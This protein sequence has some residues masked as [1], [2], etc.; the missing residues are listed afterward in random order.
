MGRHRREQAQLG[1]QHRRRVGDEQ[2]GV[3]A[4]GGGRREARQQPVTL[5]ADDR[6]GQGWNPGIG[7]AGRVEAGL[8]GDRG[9]S[10]ADRH[11]LAARR[12]QHMGLGIGSDELD[13]AQLDQEL[14]LVRQRESRLEDRVGPSQH[15]VE[16]NAQGPRV[17]AG[18]GQRLQP[19]DRARLA[20]LEHQDVA[21]SEAGEAP[22]RRQVDLEAVDVKA[23]D[24]HLGLGGLEVAG[25]E[26]GEPPAGRRLEHQLDL[27]DVELLG[28]SRQHRLL[29]RPLLLLLLLLP[30]P[31]LRL[32]TRRGFPGRQA[33]RAQHE[34]GERQDHGQ[35]APPDRAGAAMSGWPPAGHR[36]LGLTTLRKPGRRARRS[37]RRAAASRRPA[38]FAP[39]RRRRRRRRPLRGRARSPAARRRGGAGRPRRGR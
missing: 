24:A 2:Q 7:M 26:I 32:Q 22:A 3:C 27:A 6:R 23:G 38:P 16:I 39:R 21:G 19:A 1:R 29:P 31:R 36:R 12:E 8:T 11:R 20:V 13:G 15:M 33:A 5:A 34:G 28:Q 14:R 30:L 17:R 18:G 25:P 37:R 35:E 10:V 9:E 4:G